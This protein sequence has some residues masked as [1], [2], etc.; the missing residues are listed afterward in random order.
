MSVARMGFFSSDRC[1]E[2]YA[3]MIWNIEPIPPEADG[4]RDS[5]GTS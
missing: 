4:V 1:I 5:T 3:E 2:E